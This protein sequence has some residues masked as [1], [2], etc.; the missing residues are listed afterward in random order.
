LLPLSIGALLTVHSRVRLLRWPSAA[1]GYAALKS[2]RLT[3]CMCFPALLA[4][5]LPI[6]TSLTIIFGLTTFALVGEALLP[7]A[8]L[9]IGADARIG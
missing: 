6:T 2:G 5:L 9:S 7:E 4:G 3:E 1:V 8:R